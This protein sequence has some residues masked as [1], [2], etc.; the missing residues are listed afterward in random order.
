VAPG[1]QENRKFNQIFVRDTES[2]MARIRS[3]RTYEING[4]HV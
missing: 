1:K 3:S 4:N 2:V